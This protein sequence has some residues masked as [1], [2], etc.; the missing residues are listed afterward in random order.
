MA[1]VYICRLLLQAHFAG[2]PLGQLTSQ[3]RPRMYWPL[4]DMRWCAAHVR[5]WGLSGHAKP[6]QRLPET[7]GGIRADK[8]GDA[9]IWGRPR[10]VIPTKEFGGFTLVSH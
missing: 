9:G 7:P 3:S 6:P 1:I 4:A 5:S 8:C 10:V 2:Q